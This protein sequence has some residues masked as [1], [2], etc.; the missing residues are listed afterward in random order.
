MYQVNTCKT[1]RIC[2]VVINLLEL[3]LDLGILNQSWHGD[4]VKAPTTSLHNISSEYLIHLSYAKPLSAHALTMSC[5]IKQ[6][7]LIEFV[8]N[9]L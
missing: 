4:V 7:L 6:V 3:L 8:L 5:I 1:F 2:E 9:I